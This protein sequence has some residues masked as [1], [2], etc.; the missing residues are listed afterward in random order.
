MIATDME[1][2]GGV[3]SSI[4]TGVRVGPTHPDYDDWMAGRRLLTREV[5][6]A[7]QGAKDGGCDEIVVS[8]NHGRGAN[9]IVEDLHP[10]AEYVIAGGHS[11][12]IALDDSFDAMALVGFHAMAGTPNGILEHTKDYD[13]VSYAV[14]GVEMGEIGMAAILAGH[15]DVPIIFISSDD[16]G[17]AEAKQLLGQHIVAVS[18]KTGYWREG[19]KLKAPAKCREL[20]QTGLAEAIAL[21]GSPEAKPFK[22]APPYHVIEDVVAPRSHLQTRKELDQKRTDFITRREYTQDEVPGLG[23]GDPA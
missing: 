13:V 2:I 1:G 5:N 6:A 19:G 23:V 9:F 7:V 4:Q 3:Y 20:V 21:V 17:C 10:D 16:A 18:L 11:H 14:N 15:F 12:W 22:L 8:D